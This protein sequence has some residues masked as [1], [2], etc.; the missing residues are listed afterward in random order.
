MRIALK[1]LFVVSN[2]QNGS[3]TYSNIGEQPPPS[4][5]EVMGMDHVANDPSAPLLEETF[6]SSIFGSSNSVRFE[7]NCSD[8]AGTY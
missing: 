3:Q 1:Q 7:Y 5:N 6:S 8:D 2:T 4:Y